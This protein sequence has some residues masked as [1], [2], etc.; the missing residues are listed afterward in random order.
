MVDGAPEDVKGL[1]QMVSTALELAAKAKA[2]L[3][4]RIVHSEANNYECVQTLE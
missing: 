3:P 4:G 2:E 1:Q